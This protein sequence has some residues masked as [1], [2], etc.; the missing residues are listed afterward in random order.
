MDLLVPCAGKSSRFPTDIPKFLLSM[1]DGRLMFELAV[2]PFIQGADSILFAVLREHD[3]RFQASSIIRQLIPDCE[4]LILDEVTRGQ[5]ETVL[6]MVEHSRLNGAFLVKDSD[7]HFEPLENYD[8]IFNY[9]SLCSAREA[10]DVKLYNKSF[11]VINEQGYI[12]GTVEKEITSELF[13][14]GGYFFADPQ[15]YIEGFNRYEHLQ[16]GG[17]FYLSQIIDLMIESGHVF[18]PMRCREYQDWGTHKDWVAYRKRVA[19][20]LID[21]DGV[22]YE[23]GSRF[24]PPQWGS[25]NV[26]DSARDK[27]NQL[28]ETG[29]YIVLIT[30]RPEEFRAVTEG[31]LRQDHVGY[32][33]LVMGV[34]HGTRVVVND[35]APSNP[36][37]AAVA[38]NTRRDSDDFAN[39]M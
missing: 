23:N 20:Y 25:N 38:V 21:I 4:I 39:T 6:R 34:H 9:I 30:S 13:S 10:P 14:C 36:Y 22:I 3:D 7:S 5:A 31:Q 17:E 29:N 19:T 1:P 2:A 11:A 26:Y 24:W 35:F 28:F 16:V 8:P 32:H 18:R 37:P 12:V 15:S 27:I 33:Q